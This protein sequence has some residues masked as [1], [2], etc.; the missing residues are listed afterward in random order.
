MD[1][2][3]KARDKEEK[4]RLR[5]GG[6]AANKTLRDDLAQAAMAAII[7]TP[8]SMTLKGGALLGETEISKAAYIFA[9][10]MIEEGRT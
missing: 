6:P 2:I 8:G 9:D 10:A 7:S 4:E 1:M 5:S 3:Q